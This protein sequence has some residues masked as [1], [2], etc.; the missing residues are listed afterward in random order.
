MTGR[1]YHMAHCPSCKF[2]YLA[3]ED[4]YNESPMTR[5]VQGCSEGGRAIYLQGCTA[6]KCVHY[7]K[8]EE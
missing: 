5:T 1:K 3:H 8:K 4:L 6:I 7:V 2:H